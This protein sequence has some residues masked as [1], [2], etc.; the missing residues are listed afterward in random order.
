MNLLY[1]CSTYRC[2]RLRSARP[3][4]LLLVDQCQSREPG[5]QLDPDVGVARHPGSDPG[6]SL[7]H[8]SSGLVKEKSADKWQGLSAPRAK[9]SQTEKDNKF[10]KKIQQGNDFNPAFMLQNWSYLTRGHFPPTE[11][12]HNWLTG[13]N[14]SD[15]I[16]EGRLHQATS[17]AKYINQTICSLT[18]NI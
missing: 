12:G 13:A 6:V 15:W 5:D 18:S 14:V 1:L 17:S 16:C 10:W 9:V 4:M 8:P 11:C 2:W 7:N 3:P